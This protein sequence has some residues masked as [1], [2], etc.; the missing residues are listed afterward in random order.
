M[1]SKRKICVKVIGVAP[2]NDATLED[3]KAKHPFKHAP[4]LPPIL[5][6]HQLITS[7]GVVIGVAPY[8]D[9]T[10]EDLKAKHPFKHAPFLPPIP[11]D[12]QLI[13]SPGGS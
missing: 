6:D 3:L 8:N 5:I 9:A 1:S 2:Y 11:I 7:P 13:T 10:L 12:H 4:F